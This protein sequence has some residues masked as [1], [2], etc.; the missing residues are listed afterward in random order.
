MLRQR[1]VVALAVDVFGDQEEERL[2]AVARKRQEPA[3]LHVSYTTFCVIYFIHVSYSTFLVLCT[4]YICCVLP[5]CLICYVFGDQQ[6]ER[7]PAVARECQ[8][9]AGMHLFN[10]SY[11]CYKLHTCFVYHMYTT[12]KCYRLVYLIHV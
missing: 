4:T 3:C 1:G 5:F 2:P 12:Y 7:L 6:E 9:P 8:Q 11:M 10:T